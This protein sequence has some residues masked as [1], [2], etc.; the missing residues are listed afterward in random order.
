MTCGETSN[1]FEYWRK[2]SLSDSNFFKASV[3]LTSIL[4]KRLRSK[5]EPSRAYKVILGFTS[6]VVSSG[7]REQI[8]FLV[9]ENLVDAVVTTAGGVE[10]DIIKCIGGETYLGD[11][12][13][14][15]SELREEGLN[16]VGN[17][18]IPNSNYADFEDFMQPVFKD[19]SSIERAIS[20]SELISVLGKKVSSEQSIYYWCNKHS[21][22]V[23]C[24]AITDGSIGDMVFFYNYKRPQFSIDVLSDVKKLNQLISGSH[25]GAGIILLGSGL[26]KHHILRACALSC[27]VKLEIVQISTTDLMCADHTQF[28]QIYDAFVV[29]LRAEATIIFPI[30]ISLTREE[31]FPDERTQ[32]SEAIS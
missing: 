32:E 2:C 5:L 6:N 22:P 3:S 24:P 25:D 11:F 14:S 31:L 29:S 1:F 17:L 27:R 12:T 28:T 8:N 13:S 16:R 19:L 15:G 20:P 30:M 18:L 21:I 9:R 4:K 10:E 23:F 7:L 26:P